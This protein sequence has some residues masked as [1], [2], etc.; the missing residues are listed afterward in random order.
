M[1]DDGADLG[2]LP[3][4]VANLPV[5]DPAVG[6]DD[7]CVEERFAFLFQADQLVSQPC[8]RV[9]LAAAGRM[10]NEIPGP[11]PLAAASASSL[12]TT[13]SWW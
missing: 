7:N 11:T 2:E 12:R 3:D 8:D 4:G 5:K 9:G 13:S 1:A 10:L 6:D